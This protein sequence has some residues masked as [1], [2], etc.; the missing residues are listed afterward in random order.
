MVDAAAG[1]RTKI[2]VG[3][4]AQRLSDAGGVSMAV[5]AEQGVECGRESQDQP[6]EQLTLKTGGAKNKGGDAGQQG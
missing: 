4:Q 6:L 2:M 1:L 5:A 3:S